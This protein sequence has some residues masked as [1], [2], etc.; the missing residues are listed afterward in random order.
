MRAFGK[1]IRSKDDRS[2]RIRMK[3]PNCGAINE[4]TA[5]RCKK[6]NMPFGYLKWLTEGGFWISWRMGTILGLVIAAVVLPLVIGTAIILSSELGVQWI[7]WPLA[8]TIVDAVLLFKLRDSL[9]RIGGFGQYKRD[10]WHR[11]TQ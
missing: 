2:K 5:Q 9:K 6:C 8:V 1:T 10:W 4:N 3:C 11:S 7:V